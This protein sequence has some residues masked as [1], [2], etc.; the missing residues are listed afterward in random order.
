M[1]KQ[2][3]KKKPRTKYSLT[4]TKY[5]TEKYK[6]FG[7]FVGIEIECF[8]PNDS[9]PISPCYLGQ[10]DDYFSTMKRKLMQRQIQNLTVGYDGSINPTNGH[11]GVEFKILCKRTDMSNLKELCSFLADH[12]AQVNRSCGLHVHFD[13][14]E[15]QNT[16]KDKVRTN[17]N[18]ALP[19]VSKIVPTSRVNSS[20][21]RPVVSN[22]K[23]SAF[24]MDTPY[25]TIEVRL[26]SG[27]INYKKISNWISLIMRIAK[28]KDMLR[29]IPHTM[30]DFFKVVHLDKKLQKY[31]EERAT[32]FNPDWIEKE[33]KRKS[34]KVA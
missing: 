1:K 6:Q 15:M 19:F 27:T 30:E 12:G 22:A 3:V 28:S 17:F 24:H 26:H 10:E 34:K 25:D 13:S 4:T 21:C 33:K 11:F 20:F 7:S 9:F 5:P 32:L 18:R 2:K 8:L 16:Y 31:Y 23:M 14:R 29:K